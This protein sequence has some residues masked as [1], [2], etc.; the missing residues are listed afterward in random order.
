MLI[1]FFG[2][3]YPLDYYLH[4]STF[5]TPPRD[6]RKVENCATIFEN[7]SEKMALTSRWANEGA[8]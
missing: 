2:N 5:I 7:N 4:N 8:L 6:G 3:F 1:R